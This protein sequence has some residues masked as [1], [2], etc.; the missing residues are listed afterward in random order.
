MAAFEFLDDLIRILNDH[1]EAD[2]LCFYAGVKV[3]VALLERQFV[4]S[5][6]QVVF[7]S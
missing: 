1:L 5:V 7:P 2:G 3:N 4:R 6:I